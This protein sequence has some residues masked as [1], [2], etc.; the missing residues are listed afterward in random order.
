MGYKDIRTEIDEMSLED[1]Q[2]E[3]KNKA[4]VTRKGEAIRGLAI[5][6]LIKDDNFEIKIVVFPNPI[7][8]VTNTEMTLAHIMNIAIAKITI[9]RRIRL[10]V[11]HSII[12]GRG[13]SSSIYFCI[14]KSNVIYV[15]SGFR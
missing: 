11:V 8:T 10:I 6:K 14:Y 4:R 2:K 15:C 13:I 1:L 3:A 9:M 12:T 5:E 7:I